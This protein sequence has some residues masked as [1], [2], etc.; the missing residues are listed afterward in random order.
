LWSDD[1]PYDQVLNGK[2]GRRLSDDP[3][4][5]G[6]DM[7]AGKNLTRS[8]RFSVTADEEHAQGGESTSDDASVEHDYSPSVAPRRCRQYSL[9]MKLTPIH[10]SNK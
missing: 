9:N 5:S 2:A 4:R 7:D 10:H 6:D 1:I 3:D 8:L